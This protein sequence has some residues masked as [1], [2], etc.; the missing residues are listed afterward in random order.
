MSGLSDLETSKLSINNFNKH[1]SRAQF[2]CRSA[3]LITIYTYI[4]TGVFTIY[5]LMGSIYKN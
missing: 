2:V 5:V 4:G 1:Y 3:A